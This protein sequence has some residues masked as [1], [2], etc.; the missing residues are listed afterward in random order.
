MLVVANTIQVAD[1]DLLTYYWNCQSLRADRDTEKEIWT[2]I[3]F[4][5][6]ATRINRRVVIRS[7]SSF[8]MSAYLE[9]DPQARALK[10]ITLIRL[11]VRCGRHRHVQT[12]MASY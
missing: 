4:F 11:L 5:P 6:R 1:D 7:E 10:Q 3:D 12:V 9:Y 8:K 2:H